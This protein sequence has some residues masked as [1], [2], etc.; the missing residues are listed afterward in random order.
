MVWET[1]EVPREP[2]AGPWGGFPGRGGWEA[3]QALP[4]TGSHRV[5][6]A[7]AHG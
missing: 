5:E 2:A 4:V 7:Y 3:P 1:I 6:D